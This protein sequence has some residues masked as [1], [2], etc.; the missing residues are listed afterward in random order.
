[1]SHQDSLLTTDFRFPGQTS[2]YHGKVRDVYTLNNGKVVIVSTNRISAFD[3]VFPLPIPYK[4]QVLNQLAAHFLNATRDIVPNWLESTPDPNVGFGILADPVKVEVVVRG[5]LVGSAWRDYQS[6]AREL[7]GIPLPEGMQ[8]FDA[9]PTPIITPTTKAD[10]G[11]D[12]NISETEIIAQGLATPQEWA[13]ICDYALKVFGRGQQMARERGL[14]LADTKYEFGRVNGEIILIDEIHTP[15]SSRYFYADG[16][17]AYVAGDKTTRVRQLS[18]EFVREWLMEHGFSGQEG[19]A[20][21]ELTGDFINS[22]TE[23]YIELYETMTGQPF[24]KDESGDV[25]QR[26]ETNVLNTL[27]AEEK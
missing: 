4:G 20:M 1:M 14:V 21:P 22:I 2:L 15:D 27:N 16:Y 25:L 23:R 5:C 3:V 26:I 6:G 11:H 7:C 8:E 17:D 13:Q 19:Q 10:E 9:F 18:K 12:L 24:I